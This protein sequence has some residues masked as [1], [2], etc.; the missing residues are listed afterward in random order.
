MVGSVVT[1]SCTIRRHWFALEF[2]CQIQG[3]KRSIW[4]VMTSYSL[5]VGS[6]R[7]LRLVSPD[8]TRYLQSGLNSQNLAIHARLQ[9]SIES[10]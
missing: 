5:R 3:I 2:M 1:V 9:F 4:L 7:A 10:T 6:Y 8:L